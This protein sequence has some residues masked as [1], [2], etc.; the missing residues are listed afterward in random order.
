[1]KFVWI[2]D[3]PAKWRYV[4]LKHTE[5]PGEMSDYLISKKSSSPLL[6][7]TQPPIE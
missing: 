2:M 7:H 6:G 3:F 5:S 4:F 1:M